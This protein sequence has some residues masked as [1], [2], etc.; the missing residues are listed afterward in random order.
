[1]VGADNRVTNPLF[2][3]NIDA[4][5]RFFKLPVHPPAETLIF[6]VTHDPCPMCAAAIALAGFKEL[7]V[8]KGYEDVE[9]DCSLKESHAMYR[10]IFG[11]DGIRHENNFFTRRSIRKLVA[12]STNR[13]ELQTLL[14]CVDHKFAALR[15]GLV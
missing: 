8:L 6:L 2:H 1:M 3:G 11:V 12:T 15:K 9:Q 13:E 7:W 10:D 5:N 14:D 4:I